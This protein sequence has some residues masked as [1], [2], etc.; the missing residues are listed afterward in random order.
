MDVASGS[1]VVS[2]TPEQTAEAPSST[3]ESA[4]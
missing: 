4:R 2:L 3:T 1:P